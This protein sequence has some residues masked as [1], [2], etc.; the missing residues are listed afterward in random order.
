MVAALHLLAQDWIG[1]QRVRGV[2][3][4]VLRAAAV[5]GLIALTV[6]PSIVLGRAL[7]TIPNA[8]VAQ[9]VVTAVALAMTMAWLLAGWLFGA[10]LSFDF[11]FR[12]LLILP[13]SFRRLFLLRAVASLGGR[14]LLFFGASLLAIAR[15]GSD[16][17][18][19]LARGLAGVALWALAM[20]H[21]VTAGSV[22]FRS[23]AR[24]GRSAI[25]LFAVFTL[26]S[27]A[28]FTLILTGE[29]A[30]ADAI[31]TVLPV[32]GRLPASTVLRWSPPGAL[33]HLLTHGMPAIDLAVLAA[34]A[35]AALWLGARSLHAAYFNPSIAVADAGFLTSGGPPGGP[36]AAA[37]RDLQR[38]LVSAELTTL[39]RIPNI[40]VLFLF[41]FAYCPIFALMMARLDGFKF[42]YLL[43]LLVLPFLLTATLKSNLF[44]LDAKSNVSLLTLP[45][46]GAQVLRAKLLGV[47]IL[48]GVLVLA[49]ASAVAVM[50]PRALT[51]RDWLSAASLVVATFLVTNVIGGVGSV[52]F[53]K[54]I[55]WGKAFPSANEAGANALILSVAGLFAA[56]LAAHTL[57]RRLAWPGLTMEC[58]AAL[59]VVAIAAYVPYRR[60]QQTALAEHRDRLL[61]AARR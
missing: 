8:A 2:V 59:L 37:D 54:A 16:S 32:A 6:P 40:R 14:W 56:A 44:G 58:T 21:L 13:I 50:R 25:G 10:R 17:T 28:L 19:E 15:V 36:W 52:R 31:A 46:T 47:N 9:N 48:T 12:R 41:A 5:L 26:G 7:S 60:W 27:V 57:E 34:Y 18:F 24:R 11:D 33:G 3:P 45:V 38:T 42:A 53:P 4:L 22:R 30:V 20:S 39:A 61:A 49:V 51:W 1:E 55:T 23:W 29:A 35:A 43:V